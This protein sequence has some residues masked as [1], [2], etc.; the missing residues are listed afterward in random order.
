MKQPEPYQWMNEGEINTNMGTKKKNKTEFNEGDEVVVA[1]K[2]VAV[3]G[4]AV[5]LEI[6]DGSDE[7]AHRVTL[8][9][10]QLEAVTGV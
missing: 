5:T 6:T 3:E 4:D 9:G 10:S 8:N 7:R 1:A 2:V